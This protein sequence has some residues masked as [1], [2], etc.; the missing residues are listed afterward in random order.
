[1]PKS[2]EDIA[3]PLTREEITAHI[4]LTGDLSGL[5]PVERWEYIQAYCAYLGLDP[6]TRPFDLLHTFE[7]NPDERGRPIEKITL[8]ANAG[9]SAQ[10]AHIRQITYSR[11]EWDHDKSLGILK[12]SVQASFVAGQTSA[13]RTVWRSGVAF[14]EGLKG[15]TLENAIKKAETQA[16]RR[17]TLAL[18]GVAMPDESEVEDIPGA[19]AIRINPQAIHVA[20]TV[21]ET[22]EAEEIFDTPRAL[23]DKPLPEAWV[24]DTPARVIADQQIAN[25]IAGGLKAIHEE[26]KAEA[27]KPEPEAPV[28]QGPVADGMKQ[29]IADAREKNIGPSAPPPAQANPWAQPRPKYDQ[30]NR[31]HGVAIGQRLDKAVARLTALKVRGE[32]MVEEINAN[33]R[34]SGQPVISSRYELDN[35]QAQEVCE[36]FE[37]MAVR[38]ESERL[39]SR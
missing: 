25:Q 6:I 16:H 38:L 29:R 35:A 21:T 13:G 26:I 7:K 37:Q 27:P 5:T 14:V 12:I 31:A 11:P 4:S 23:P 36:I 39:K 17:A 28:E 9:C 33:I 10:L 19:T 34:R 2:S 3:K 22:P 20:Q 1:M 18:C 24:E 15:R 32:T 8:Y 30:K